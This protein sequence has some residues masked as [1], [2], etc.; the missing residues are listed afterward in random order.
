MLAFY[1]YPFFVSGAVIVEGG[2]RKPSNRISIRPQCWGPMVITWLAF[3]DV[4]EPD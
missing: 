1:D 3:G 4:N 2:V